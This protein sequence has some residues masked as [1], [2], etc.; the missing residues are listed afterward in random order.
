MLRNRMKFFFAGGFLEAV[1]PRVAGRPHALIANLIEDQACSVIDL[2]AGTGYLA[3]L[4]AQ[5]APAAAITAIDLSPE[6]IA[7]GKR[8]AAGA[9]LSNVSWQLGDVT[10][11]PFDDSSFNVAMIS[12]GLHELAPRAR[13][14]ALR[15]AR[16]I[17]QPG[18][19]LLIVDVDAPKR[20]RRTFEVYLLLSHGST[21]RKVLGAGLVSLLLDAGFEVIT[22]RGG[23]GGLLPFQ[24]IEAR[25]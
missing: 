24:F 8:K 15:E 5:K 10:W 17:L 14:R 16:R 21:A 3:R 12:F 6:L 13:S 7:V 2:C 23:L 9:G 4:V 20:W 1:N 11:L 25:C 19:R 22:H 18:G